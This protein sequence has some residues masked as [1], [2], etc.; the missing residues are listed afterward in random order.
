MLNLRLKILL[1]TKSNR[2]TSLLIHVHF[3]I[4]RLLNI[5]ALLSKNLL[6]K[7]GQSEK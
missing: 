4:N 6:N 2:L 5:T 7:R 3:N 1:K